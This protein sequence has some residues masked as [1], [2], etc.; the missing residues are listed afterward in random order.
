MWTSQFVFSNT[1]QINHETWLLR[2]SLMKAIANAC[3]KRVQPQWCLETKQANALPLT[4]L[5]QIL[6]QRLSDQS[7]SHPPFP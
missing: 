2:A 6:M 1:S 5:P 3:G 7:N 4:L